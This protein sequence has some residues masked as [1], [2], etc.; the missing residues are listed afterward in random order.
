M[1]VYN[2][3]FLNTEER[4]RKGIFQ[5][6]PVKS[7]YLP[8]PDHLFEHIEPHLVFPV[9]GTLVGTPEITNENGDLS[10]GF[11]ASVSVT[12]Q[13]SETMK[14]PVAVVISEY[15]PWCTRPWILL[16]VDGSMMLTNGSTYNIS[17]HKQL[18]RADKTEMFLSAARMAILRNT[19]GALSTES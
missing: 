17:F 18:A 1:I 19:P 10:I 12:F 3:F 14:A 15:T 6:A 2:N 4:W 8:H 7:S 11:T 13:V 5:V 9:S 16:P